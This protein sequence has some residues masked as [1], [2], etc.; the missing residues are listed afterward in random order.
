MKYFTNAQIQ[1]ALTVLRPYSVFFST[2]FL[3][4]KQAQVPIGSTTVFGLDAANRDFLH[5][6]FRI[7]PKSEHFFRVDRQTR[8]SQDWSNPNYASTSLQSINTQTFR[9]VLLHPRRSNLW[10]WHGDYVHRLAAKL[11]GD[12]Q[13]LPLFHLGVWLYKFEPWDDDVRRSDVV[14]RVMDDYEISGDELS[15]LFESTVYSDVPEQHTFQSHPVQWHEILEPFSRPPDVPAE[16]S[17]VLKHLETNHLGP[18][19]KTVFTPANRM[20][21]V[22]G[23]NG[24]GKTFLLD[25]AWWALTRDWVDLRPTPI[26]PTPGRIPSIQFLVEGGVSSRPNVAEYVGGD[27]KLAS[28]E[29][30]LPGLVVYARVDGSFAIWD[31]ANRAL[32][33]PLLGRGSGIK[34]TRE[35]VWN[36]KQGQ[37]EGLIRDLVSW[38]QRPD[39]HPRFEAFQTVLSQI[40][41]PDIGPTRLGSTRTDTIRPTRNPYLQA[42]VRGRTNPI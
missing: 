41:P 28:D 9:D 2:T 31:P 21:L 23:D 18:A 40:Y 6:H 25:L 13:K 35:E 14:D 3:V 38:Q 33:Q 20:N 36:G 37:I 11:P 4:L 24:L 12:W 15:S 17:G 19:T 1:E 26:N 34:L 16:N 32:S 39:L 22:T 8:S 42:S 29:S 30:G 27:W 7:H 10:G 5:Q